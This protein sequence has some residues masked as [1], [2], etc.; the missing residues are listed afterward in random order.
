MKKIKII[1]ILHSVGG[2]DVS[3]RLIVENTDTDRF[4][5]IVIHGLND[6]NSDF[7]DKNGNKLKDYK[8]SISRN[9]SPFN[10]ILSL[11]N[12]YKI[13]KSEKPEIIHAHSAK[14][15]VIGRIVGYLLGITVLYTPQAF[16]YLSACNKIKRNLFLL[17]EKS[18]TLKNSYLLA[19]STSE[20][21]RA[22]NEV[23]YKKENVLLFDNSINPIENTEGLSIHKTWPVDYICT[24]GRPSYQKNIELMIQVL[25]EV[26]KDKDIHLVIMGV[27]HHSDKLEDVKKLIDKLKLN[28]SVTLI[29]WTERENIFHIID[30]SKFYISTARYEGLPYS[31]I[32]AM[33]LSKP[34]VVSDCDGN[35]DLIQNDYN[36]FVLKDDDISKFSDKI[37]LLL[38]DHSLLR[39]LS[40]NAK[41]CFN[42]NYNIQKNIKKLEE[43]YTNFSV[44]EN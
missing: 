32:E 7:I 27:G 14:G 4:Q 44:K 2:V 39:K 28:N 34:C 31:V 13:V 26:R 42:E 19:S 33:A 38:D 16:S 37:K 1:H 3:L 11:I 6:T 25:N 12:T 18:L 10:D 5:N 29:D 30:N 15:G 24:V 9:I 36:G 35:R 21:V 40:M 22:I 23:K 43:I 17:I 8:I 20:M 41:E